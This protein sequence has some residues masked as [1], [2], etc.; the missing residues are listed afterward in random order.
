MSFFESVKDLPIEIDGY[1]LGEL[2]KTFPS[3][4]TRP[5]TLI[6]LRGGGVEGLGEDVVY[7][8]LDH[9][10][11]R[12]AGPIHDLSGPANLGEL[13]ELIGSLDLFPAEPVRDFSR[14]YRRW[15]YE[16]AALDLALRQAGKPLHELVG[17]PL[18]P[19]NFVCS[20]RANAVEDSEDADEVLKPI[21]DRLD[22]YPGL[23]FKLDPQPDWDDDVISFLLESGAVD[24]LDLKGCYAGTP[25]DVDFEPEDYNRL[26][27]SFPDAW[28]ED[29]K[30]T[31]ET[32]P[33]LEP[34]RERI[35]WDAPI[36]SVA[37]IEA[38]TWKPK[39]VNVKPSR[40]G[41]LQSLSDAYSY[42]E[43]EGIGA[44]G[45]G[46]TELSVGRDHIQYLAAMMHP[47][48]PNDVAPRE[49]NETEVPD[50][51]PSSPLRLQPLPAGFGLEPGA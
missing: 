15:A 43:R 42:C 3:G 14:L 45:G 38:L 2:D 33:V 26:A 40:I 48:T 44:Y 21:T 34:H 12:D 5:S 31:P 37:D 4:F 6:T 17:R 27:L 39:I 20:V 35:T 8:D 32:I 28:L 29:P 1:E 46:Q 36:H 10:A 9:F 16:S 49:Y 41:G 30:M 7:D 51:L 19:L 23:R 11:H 47:G 18:E 22:K 24:S 13:C 50:G 25:V